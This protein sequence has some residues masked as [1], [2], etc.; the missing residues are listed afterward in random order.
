[1]KI[2]INVLLQQYLLS[3]MD[4]E[5]VQISYQQIDM[6]QVNEWL[7]FHHLL[8]EKLWHSQYNYS[9][10]HPNNKIGSSPCTYVTYRVPFRNRF[11][12][13]LFLIK[14]I[15]FY[16]YNAGKYNLESTK[17]LIES[18]LPGL[19]MWSSQVHPAYT[20]ILRIF[21]F[22]ILIKCRNGINISP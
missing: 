4:I 15:W 19:K 5:V 3:K 6:F 2:R 14:T 7:H 11:L 21:Y 17:S 12:H 9:P 13:N 1:M 16:N 10:F 18:N 22:F 20:Q 8:I